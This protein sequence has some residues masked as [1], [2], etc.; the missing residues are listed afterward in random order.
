MRIQVRL[1]QVNPAVYQQVKACPH[2]G[3]KHFKPHGQKGHQKKVRDVHHQEV[4]SQRL[5]CMR[6]KRTF[7]IY[8]QG[9]S[10]ADQSDHLKGMSVLLYVLGLSYGG[11]S[12]FLAALGVFIGKTT[13]YD[14]VQS[15]GA[16]SRQQGRRAESSAVIGSDGTY[17]KVKGVQ[18]GIQVVV[19]DSTQDL[20]GLELVTSENSPEMLAVLRDIAQA[21]GAEVLVSDDLDSYKEVADEL[22]LDHQICRKHVKDNVDELVDELFEQLQDEEPIPEGVDSS[23][24]MLAMDLALIQWLVWTRPDQA[25]DFWRDLYH[26]YQAAP[27]P[28]SGRK[29]PIW[30]RM[31]M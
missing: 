17:V 13:V 4:S 19:D 2:C 22:G 6:C 25:A 18:V 5:K 3:G 26:R 14:N 15:A 23:P 24:E 21:V 11:V 29:H 28:P 27:K 8:P 9:V 20:L 10:Q 30:Y 31:R 1:P 12:D 16:A 7:R